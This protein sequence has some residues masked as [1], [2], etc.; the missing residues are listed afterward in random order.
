MLKPDIIVTY[1]I[2]VLVIFIAFLL[3][4]SFI[5]GNCY[6]IIECGTEH[7]LARFCIIVISLCVPLYIVQEKD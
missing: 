3:I 5:L 7:H 2:L 1:I 6:W 4:I